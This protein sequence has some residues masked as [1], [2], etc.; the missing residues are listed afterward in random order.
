MARQ[1]TPINYANNDTP[2]TL[3]TLANDVVNMLASEV[4]T[5]NASLNGALTSGNGY[6]SGIFGASVIV[7]GQLRGGSVNASAN[8]VMASNL[9]NM[10]D[11]I[12]IKSGNTVI[13]T[14][15]IVVD[16]LVVNTAS[17]NSFAL[18]E[19]TIGNTE[20]RSLTFE[21]NASANQ[22]F[23]SFVMSAYRSAEYL[24]SMQDTS[25][26]ANAYQVMKLLVLHDGGSAYVTEY[27]LVTTNAAAGTAG[28]I[29][30]VNAI[31]NGASVYITVSPGAAVTNLELQATRIIMST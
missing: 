27:G 24:L 30:T 19:I 11:S 2:I 21:A 16:N 8:V 29:G 26:S 4:V 22:V 10:N 28:I 13:N 17:I 5:A 1:L 18:D 6:V 14:T 25:S 3:I 9:V 12:I 20:I 15:A 7:A 23:D 31:A